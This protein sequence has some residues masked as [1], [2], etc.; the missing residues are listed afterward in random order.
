MALDAYVESAAKAV[1]QLL[2]SVPRPREIVLSGRLA[3][4]GRVR[5]AVERTLSSWAPVR[6]LAGFARVAKEAAQGA[7]LIADGLAGGGSRPLVETMRLS[8]ARGTVLDHLYV[9]TPDM[10]RRRLG[11][12]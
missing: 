11:L 8:E 3:R 2:V 7:A 6:S 9:I 12:G 10:A 5:C 1:V 4:P